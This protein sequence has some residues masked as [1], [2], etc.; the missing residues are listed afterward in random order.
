MEVLSKLT[1]VVTERLRLSKFKDRKSGREPEH[2]SRLTANHE[3]EREPDFQEYVTRK[4]GEL[5]RSA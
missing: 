3:V 2:Q 1:Q 5:H 4:S